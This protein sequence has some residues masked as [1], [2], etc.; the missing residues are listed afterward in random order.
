MMSETVESLKKQLAELQAKEGPLNSERL[1]LDELI[2]KLNEFRAIAGGKTC[3]S[4]ECLLM[5][6]SSLWHQTHRSNFR[7]VDRNPEALSRWIL[8]HSG[9]LKADFPAQ[10]LE[11]LIDLKERANDPAPEETA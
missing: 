11:V 7:K 9:S 6:S 8:E 10:V 2:A 5:G 4:F 1:T 3:V